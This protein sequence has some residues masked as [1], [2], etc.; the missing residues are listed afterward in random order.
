MWLVFT[1]SIKLLQQLLLL[2]IISLVPNRKSFKTLNSFHSFV[3]NRSLN[4]SYEL[5][6]EIFIVLRKMKS[7][8]SSTYEIMIYCLKCSQ[9]N[10]NHFCSILILKLLKVTAPMR[11]HAGVV[12]AHSMS[13]EMI[14]V[15]SGSS[16]WLAEQE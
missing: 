8:R 15:A 6:Q 1:V 12:L 3:L 2:Q 10:V 13:T 16:L 5:A 7:N 9:L 14:E 4:T 11:E